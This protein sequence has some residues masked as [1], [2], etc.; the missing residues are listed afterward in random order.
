MILGDD[1]KLMG[2]TA[3]AAKAALG[4]AIYRRPP[5]YRKAGHIQSEFNKEPLAKRCAH[6]VQFLQDVELMTH[7]DYFVGELP[8]PPCLLATA[9]RGLPSCHSDSARTV[10]LTSWH[11]HAPSA[12]EA[13]LSCFS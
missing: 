3:K 2:E 4:C 8:L 1:H 11:D 9:L 7:A 5:Y 6:T 12:M 13:C 10:L